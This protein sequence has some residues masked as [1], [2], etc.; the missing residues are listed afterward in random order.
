MPCKYPFA[1]GGFSMN[2]E[3]SDEELRRDSSIA[4]IQK[5][6]QILF[7]INCHSEDYEY[8][9]GAFKLLES[10]STPDEVVWSNRILSSSID[11]EALEY[12]LRIKKGRNLISMKFQ[13]V[14]FVAEAFPYTYD[15]LINE[16][17]SSFNGYLRIVNSIFLSIFLFIKGGIIYSWTAKS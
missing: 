7:K 12:F 10:H 8:F 3:K 9:S 11:L 5:I 2:L 13:A 4:E 15:K 1:K 17:E 14:F 6:H 16:H